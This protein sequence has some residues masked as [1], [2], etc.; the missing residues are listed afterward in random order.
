MLTWTKT[1]DG[2]TSGRW[3]IVRMK[4]R[5]FQLVN[6]DGHPCHHGSG[7][8]C[9][10]HAE[11][12]EDS[13][14][15]VVTPMIVEDEQ[16]SDPTSALTQVSTV[17]VSA[18]SE[19][20][21]V[22]A[23]HGGQHGPSPLDGKNDE[24]GICHLCGGDLLSKFG[25][26]YKDCPTI[27]Q[28]P[29]TDVVPVAS[30]RVLVKDMPPQPGDDEPVNP[31][32]P[33][34]PKMGELFG[35]KP[36]VLASLVNR[37]KD[38]SPHLIVEARA[39]TGKTTTLIEGLKRI[40]GCPTEGFVPSP[41]QAVVFAE[42][43]RGKEFTRSVMFVAFN[44]SIAEELKARVPA[45]CEAS[46]MHGLGFRAV[47]AAFRGL[48]VEQ[49]RVSN[50]I[51][52]LLGRDIRDLRRERPTLVQ[53]TEKLVGL[54]K[55]NLINAPTDETVVQM[56][57]QHEQVK[58]L[59]RATT[60]DFGDAL[61]DLATHYDVDLEKDRAEVFALVPRV[62]ERCKDVENDRCLNFDDMIW[63]PVVLNLPVTKYDLLLI[64]ERQDLNRCQMELGLRAGRRIVAVGDKAQSIYGFA[65]AVA[66]ACE[67]FAEMLKTHNG[68]G[69]VQLP[70]TVTR[71]C[72][73]RIV[74]EARRIVPDF[75][76]FHSNLE[77]SV[78]Y[79]RM[80]SRDEVVPAN[81]IYRQLVQDGDMVLCRVNAPL[82]REC[83]RFLKA[84]RKANIQGRDIGQG[85]IS[86]VTKMKAMSVSDLV[87]RLEAWLDQETKKE[88]AKKNPSDARIE[89]LQDRLDCLMCFADGQ[90]AVDG[91]VRKIE[92]VF[93]DDKTVRGIRLSSG[94]KAK[95]LEAHR[96]FILQ[97]KG[98]SGGGKRKDGRER[99]AWEVEQERNLRY[100][101][102]TRAIHELVYVS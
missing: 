65:G 102:I 79:S 85:L 21:G 11:L 36:S 14:G 71:R 43:E 50:I 2:W 70:L 40:K 1:A 75:E 29:K 34:G 9:K 45:G 94:H 58:D 37:P 44:K 6:G 32:N 12:V 81:L 76:A 74:A 77:G 55:M 86:T 54:C 67:R 26:H 83:F 82:V 101:M 84:E 23:N 4:P 63:L 61:A 30:A 95:G 17:A 56:Q 31:T 98:C 38:D 18:F 49:H 27:E 100:V 97:G 46:T 8:A 16:G 99:P 19:P 35:R 92:S 59:F 15:S 96:V 33:D 7:V 53:A 47:N 24:V 62:L 5:Y 13:K 80:E 20:A 66:Y 73:K 69:V 3:T 42:M 68:R 52:E 91:V 25:G 41:Q 51:A 89:A 88:L 22:P 57:K 28:L 72:G 39:G 10:S 90:T 87:T 78:V 48:R 64:D 93:T 60:T